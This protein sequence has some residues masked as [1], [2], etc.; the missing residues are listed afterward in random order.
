MSPRPLPLD[1]AAMSKN[2]LLGLTTLLILAALPLFAGGC[3]LLGVA[4]LTPLDP[5]SEPSVLK[6]LIFEGDPGDSWPREG[7]V[8]FWLRGS[9]VPIESLGDP[10]HGGILTLFGSDDATCSSSHTDIW[11]TLWNPLAEGG[12]LP[13][14]AEDASDGRVD[15]NLFALH[16]IIPSF[17]MKSYWGLTDT[18]Q[19]AQIFCGPANWV[20]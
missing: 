17:G 20:S 2:R 15:I 10:R 16:P 1:I 12:R 11:V 7:E 14:T 8:L 9:Q 18:Y 4:E 6:L 3:R 5:G 19:A 13:W